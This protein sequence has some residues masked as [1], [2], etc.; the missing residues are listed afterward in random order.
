MP[1]ASACPCCAPYTD[2]GGAGP[3]LGC[4]SG[5]VRQVVA[6]RSEIMKV[7]MR[8]AYKEAGECKGAGNKKKK[9]KRWSQPPAHSA[10]LLS[11]CNASL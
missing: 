4:D 3:G 7:R 8:T 2:V 9:K 6:K 1:C 10:R 5:R 11:E